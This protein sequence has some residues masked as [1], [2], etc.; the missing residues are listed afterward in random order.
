MYILSWNLSFLTQLDRIG[1]HVCESG[2]LGMTGAKDQCFRVTSVFD[3]KVQGLSPR[4]DQREEKSTLDM[5]VGAG[6]F[7]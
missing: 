4:R 1:S 2:Y 3:S 7:E 5:T 6:T